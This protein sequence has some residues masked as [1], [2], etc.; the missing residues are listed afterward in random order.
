[1]LNT[2]Y[3]NNIQILEFNTQEELNRHFF[4]L[5]AYYESNNKQLLRK[6]FSIKEFFKKEFPNKLN[7]KLW[8]KRINGYNIPEKYVI[9]FFSK[10]SDNELTKKEKIL[11]SI[12]KSGCYLIGVFN[13]SESKKITLQHEYIHAIFNL[14]PDYKSRVLNYML[15]DGIY[16]TNIL[17]NH[18]K[19]SNKFLFCEE[20]YYDEINAYSCSSPM[21][22][23]ELSDIDDELLEKIDRYCFD[24]YN[25]QYPLI[26]NKEFLIDYLSS[27]SRNSLN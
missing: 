8:N 26:T 16:I 18:I 3:K 14:Y 10:F 15:S 5:S 25:L 11:K 6:K 22:P 23:G 1:M 27:K 24:L 9:E 21:I 13:I 20:N 2:I 12:Y 19:Q 4:R 7:K 17:L